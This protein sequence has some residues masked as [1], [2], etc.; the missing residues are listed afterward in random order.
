MGW[1]GVLA[2]AGACLLIG[3]LWGYSVAMKYEFVSLLRGFFLQSLWVIL[4]GLIVGG[5]YSGVKW[6]LL[7]EWEE[8]LRRKEGELERSRRH[9]VSEQNRLYEERKKIDS[10][11]EKTLREI[12]VYEQKEKERI[13]RELKRRSLEFWKKLEEKNLEVYKDALDTAEEE[14]RRL[15][16]EKKRLGEEIRRLND[17]I[18]SLKG[19]LK[20][21]AENT[22]LRVDRNLL[23]RALRKRN[24]Y[25]TILDKLRKS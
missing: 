16:R 22:V 25:K 11:W 8:S 7:D 6:Y 14:I 13:E 20:Q 5:V 2:V 4:F 3:A 19:Q 1:K 18:A 17:T 12:E 24:D 9:L 21:T 10:L 15:Q 23:I